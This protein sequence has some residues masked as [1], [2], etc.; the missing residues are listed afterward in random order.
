MAG[1]FD[2]IGYSQITDTQ[3]ATQDKGGFIHI[4]LKPLG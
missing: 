4:P 1:N 3:I 2:A